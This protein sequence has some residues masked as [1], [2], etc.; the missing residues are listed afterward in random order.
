MTALASAPPVVRV[1]HL[2]A[3]SLAALWQRYG[4][5]V[6]WV[7]P[8]EAIP[9]SYWGETEAGLIGT[10][11]FVRADTP[12]HSAFHEACHFVC[13]DSAR[14]TRLH[15]DAGGEVA[16][17]D[18]VCYLQI[19]LAD[20]LPEFSRA[21]MMRDMDAWGYTFRLG[22]AHAWFNHDA[23]DALAWLIQHGLL[24]PNQTPTWQIRG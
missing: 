15:T 12:V 6:V 2:P 14:R 19:V 5:H 17:E 23:E 18:G 20:Y 3:G 16:E 13:M 1:E 24:H 8:G 21:R 9:G 7:A 22:S 10:Q 11:L 4:L